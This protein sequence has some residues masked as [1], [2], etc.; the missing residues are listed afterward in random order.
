MKEAFEL[1]KAQKE[2]L[3]GRIK[4]YFENEIGEDIGDLKAMLFLEF[5]KKEIAPIFYNLGIEDSHAYMTQRLDDI[6]ALNK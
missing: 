2:E 6:F 4:G 5:I 3:V 1:T